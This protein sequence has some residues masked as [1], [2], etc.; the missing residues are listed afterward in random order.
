[1]ARLTRARIVS[2]GSPSRARVLPPAE[3]TP[4]TLSRISREEQS[5]REEAVRIVAEA[6]RT[7][8]AIVDEARVKAAS[9]AESAGRE[10]AEA[11]RAKLAAHMLAL[12]LREERADEAGLDRAVELARVLAERLVGEALA[13]DPT[14]IA[15]LARQAL[16]EARGARTVRIEAHPDDVPALE[17]HLT[18]LGLGAHVASVTADATI[19]RGCLRLR[20]DLGTLDAHLR[21]QLE[22]LAAALRDALR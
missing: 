10:A 9:A 13:L 20:T 14:T 8:T 5:A 19:D 7:A 3:A 12:R 18:A 16:L 2:R 22:R 6:R 21:P 1:M 17:E 4:A 11:E 15:K